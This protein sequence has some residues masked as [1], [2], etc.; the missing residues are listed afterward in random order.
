M[1]NA[2]GLKLI[3]VVVKGSAVS[4]GKIYREKQC[5]IYL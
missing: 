4:T 2:V 1:G 5:K 3:M